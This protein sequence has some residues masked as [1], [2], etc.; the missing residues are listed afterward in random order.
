M[1]SHVPDLTFAYYLLS[2]LGFSQTDAVR[3]MMTPCEDLDDLTPYE[4]ATHCTD[5]VKKVLDVIT[6][7]WDG[8]ETPK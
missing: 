7:C 2:R 8:R 5:G 6:R 1:V 3:W 4:C